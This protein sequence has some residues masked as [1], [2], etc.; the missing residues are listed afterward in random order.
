M[1]SEAQDKDICEPTPKGMVTPST[2]ACFVDILTF[3]TLMFFFQPQKK[4]TEMKEPL[5]E[6]F[7]KLDP[8]RNLLLIAAVIMLLQAVQ[9]SGI[10]NAWSKSQII[11]LLVGAGLMSI[12]F[13]AWQ[14]R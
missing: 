13:I 6:R 12:V 1:V 8:I 3:L 5:R 14:L 2:A 4:E 7:L 10:N 9:W 11:G